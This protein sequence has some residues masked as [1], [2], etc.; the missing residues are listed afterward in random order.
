MIG[1]ILIPLDG[2]P[3]A[4]AVLPLVTHLALEKLPA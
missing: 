3:A 2:S 4:E 1:K